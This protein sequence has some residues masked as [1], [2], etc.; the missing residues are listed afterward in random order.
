MSNKSDDGIMD[1]DDP[2][3]S[4]ETHWSQV[5]QRHYEPDGHGD[6][7]TAIVYAI[8]AA[9]GVSPS[10]IKSPP[11]YEC[12]DVPAI[13]N[14]FFGSGVSEGSRQGTG[15]VEFHYT[16]YLVQIRSDGWIQVYEPSEPEQV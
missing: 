16:D 1:E 6:L 5:V 13:E 12:L 3:G 14:A 11:L 8:A 10:E 15:T 9:E 4:A 2:I 7:T